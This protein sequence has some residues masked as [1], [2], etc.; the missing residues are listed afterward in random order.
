MKKLQQSYWVSLKSEEREKV[1]QM[2]M[3]EATFVRK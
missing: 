1:L 2:R 3:I